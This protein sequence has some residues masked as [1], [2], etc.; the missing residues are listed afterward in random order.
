MWA[1]I[2]ASMLWG[3]TG[4]AA[5][6]LPDSVSPLAVGENS[7]WLVG[8]DVLLTIPDRPM[9]QRLAWVSRDGS[10]ESIA[11][12]PTGGWTSVSLSP[13]GARAVGTRRQVGTAS[14]TSSDLWIA[15]LARGSAS[16][17]TS[18]PGLTIDAVWSPDGRTVYYSNNG[19]GVY[20]VFAKSVAAP[21]APAFVVKGKGLIL[22][23]ASN[24]EVRPSASAAMRLPIDV[25][26]ASPIAWVEFACARPICALPSASAPSRS[27]ST[28]ASAL[29]CL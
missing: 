14:S 3:T 10:V 28:L 25:A 7:M 1:L 29:P 4:T 11:G 18:Q 22:S 19:S 12:L 13:D 16:R 20:E 27:A 15:D 8:D 2:L 26:S 21:G 6:F 24:F 23:I 9:D 5:S 17:F